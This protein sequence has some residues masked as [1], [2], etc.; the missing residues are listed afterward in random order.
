MKYQKQ[1]PGSAASHRRGVA[2][3]FSPS[4]EYPYSSQRVAI[5]RHAHTADVFRNARRQRT[6]QKFTSPQAH[7][8]LFIRARYDTR[9]GSTPFVVAPTSQLSGLHITRLSS[10]LSNTSCPRSQFFFDVHS[11]GLPDRERTGYLH[12]LPQWCPGTPA[13][14]PDVNQLVRLQL[15]HTR[16]R[17]CTAS[18]TPH[19]VDLVI[20]QPTSP[21][22]VVW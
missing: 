20:S 5:H 10:V 14:S 17:R 3:C 2:G 1:T 13:V 8:P 11:Q 15:R 21:S 6:R 16:S 7:S 12:M 9:L 4:S 22:H 18:K 19:F